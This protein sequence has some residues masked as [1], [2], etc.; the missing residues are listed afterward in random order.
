MADV[1][2]G[3]RASWAAACALGGLAFGALVA[4]NA[5][6]AMLSLG[7]CFGVPQ[8]IALWRHVRRAWSW[9]IVTA[10]AMLVA[11]IAGIVTVLVASGLEQSISQASDIPEVQRTAIG[12]V[13]YAAAMLVAGVIVGLAQSGLLPASA[14]RVW[15]WAW[16][17]ALGAVAFWVMT[18]GAVVVLG[19][20]WTATNALL[21]G[22]REPS[23]LPSIVCG[24]AS[25]G[26]AYGLITCRTLVRRLTRHA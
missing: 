6:I 13:A 23:F 24:G 9:A 3:A 14:R 26:L 4:L 19:G 15:S 17:T 10:L 22:T 5:P 12:A 25:G 21:G 2:C 18:V 7:V 1:S 20:G 8:S 16:W 11:W